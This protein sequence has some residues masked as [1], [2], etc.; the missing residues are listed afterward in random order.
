MKERSSLKW[1]ENRGGPWSGLLLNGPIKERSPLKW[2]ENR[3]QGWSL[4][5][6][7]IKRNYEGKV[8][9]KVA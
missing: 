7:A 5:R 4:V 6:A 2:P 9:A 3:E 8:F 1:P